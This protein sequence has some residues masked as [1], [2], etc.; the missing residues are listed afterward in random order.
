[1]HLGLYV[2]KKKKLASL[3][4]KH[5]QHLGLHNICW[6]ELSM[7]QLTQSTAVLGDGIKQRS[8]NIDINHIIAI[9]Q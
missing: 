1:M 9:I 7:H 5:L 8:Q 3:Y 2:G 4:L 6:R